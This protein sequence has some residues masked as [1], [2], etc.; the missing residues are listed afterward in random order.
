M[1]GGAAKDLRAVESAMDHDVLAAIGS[2]FATIEFD[3]DGVIQNAN[4]A[5]LGLMGYDLSEVKGRHHRIFTD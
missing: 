2:S 4:A 3:T 1:D 5:F